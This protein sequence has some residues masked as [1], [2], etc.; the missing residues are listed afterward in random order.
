MK[1]PAAAI[2]YGAAAL[3]GE[4]DN[5]KGTLVVSLSTLE[6]ICEGIALGQVI[7]EYRPDYVVIGETRTYSYDMLE[8]ACNFIIEGARFIGTNPDITGP[9]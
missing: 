9:K 5:L 1:G 8:K 6:E 4:K 7:E 3:L 2:V